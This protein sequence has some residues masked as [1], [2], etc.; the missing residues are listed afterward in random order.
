MGET[1]NRE[2]PA[3]NEPSPELNKNFVKHARHCSALRDRVSGVEELTC[4]LND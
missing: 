3:E 1:E 2:I 4:H